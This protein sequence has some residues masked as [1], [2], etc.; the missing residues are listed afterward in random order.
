MQFVHMAIHFDLRHP[1]SSFLP[2]VSPSFVEY[3]TIMIFGVFRLRCVSELL[4]IISESCLK[5]YYKN[6]ITNCGNK[7]EMKFGLLKP[8]T[9]KLLLPY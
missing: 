1:Y 7:T 2:N 3:C 6:Q 9:F 5:I 4:R 8:I